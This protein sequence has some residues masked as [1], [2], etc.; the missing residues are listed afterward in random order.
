MNLPDDYLSIKNQFGPFE[1]KEKGSKFISFIFPAH[2]KEDA[3]NIIL[4]LRKKYF[5]ST[6]ICYAFRIGE[7]IED[8]FRYSDD[9]EPG[10]T[11]GLP[12][13]KEISGKGLYNILT[14]VIRYYGGTKLGTGG[15][16]RAYS[17]SAKLAIENSLTKRIINVK[18]I[19]LTINYNFLGEL[20]KM[21]ELFGISIS[22]QSYNEK[23]IFFELSIPLSLF[24]KFKKDISNRSNG[25]I[26]I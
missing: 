2:S 15:L 26:S 7:G 17:G 9:G 23:G 22:D 10:G 13:Y 11:A 6:H 12:I 5:D 4:Q 16:T 21:V 8:Y 20:M 19:S 1:I 24:Q 25:K 3:E 18:K 14:A